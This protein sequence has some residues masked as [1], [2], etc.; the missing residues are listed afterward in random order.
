MGLATR[1]A[2]IDDVPAVA[3]MLHDFNTEFDTPSPG[4][5]VLLDRLGRL[6]DTTDTFAVVA[7]SPPLG[8]ALVTL[9]TNVWFDG[10]VALLDE[11]YVVPGRRG[12]GIGTR[13][14]DT[15]FDT[16]RECE[17]DLIEINVD[18]DDVGA[19]RF[20]ERHGF[21]AIEPATGEHA[22]YYSRELKR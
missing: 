14:I 18:V 3:R 2:T 20:Y 13:L 7:G 17:V 8:L 11:L 22:L 12:E 6:L 10:R 4:P 9:R 15:L 1:L 5:D 21:A 16:A 19:R